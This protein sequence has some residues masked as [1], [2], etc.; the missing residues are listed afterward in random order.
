MC[1]KAAILTGADKES[2]RDMLTLDVIPRSVGI[3]TRDGAYEV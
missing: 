1:L 2:L 3:E